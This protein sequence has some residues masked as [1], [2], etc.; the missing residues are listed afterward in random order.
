M[1]Q[2]ITFLQANREHLG[3]LVVTAIPIEGTVLVDPKENDTCDGISAKICL[4]GGYAN[5]LAARTREL[6][7]RPTS[8]VAGYL[9]ALL[10]R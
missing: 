3:G 6:L 5:I 2:L 10:G 7:D 8:G 4:H 9:G 1:D